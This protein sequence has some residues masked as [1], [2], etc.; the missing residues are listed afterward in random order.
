MAE[1]PPSHPWD[2][3]HAA[4]SRFARYIEF[5]CNL[6]HNAWKKNKNKRTQQSISVLFK[7]VCFSWLRFDQSW[8]WPGHTLHS[9]IPYALFFDSLS[10]VAQAWAAFSITPVSHSVPWMPAVAGETTNCTATELFF[11]F[12][13]QRALIAPQVTS[14]TSGGDRWRAAASPRA[15]PGGCD[16]WAHEVRGQRRGVENTRLTVGDDMTELSGAVP[17]PTCVPSPPLNFHL[18]HTDR[19]FRRQASVKI[20]HNG[21]LCQ[22]FIWMSSLDGHFKTTLS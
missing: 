9:F 17:P 7:S 6:K 11:L 21:L 22:P 8:Q 4:F 10:F 2:I 15:R 1:N 20:T 19:A 12:L 16:T 5:K 14:L 18:C 13:W 3:Q